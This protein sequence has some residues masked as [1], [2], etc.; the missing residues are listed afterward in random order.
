MTALILTTILIVTVLCLRHRQ[1]KSTHRA[2]SVD[3]ESTISLPRASTPRQ[4]QLTTMGSM[5]LPPHTN[6][7]AQRDH[8]LTLPYH[9]IQ[10]QHIIP[11]TGCV[12]YSK[13]DYAKVDSPCHFRPV[14]LSHQSDHIHSSSPSTV[15][16][17]VP[18]MSDNE[19][20][21]IRECLGDTKNNNMVPNSTSTPAPAV[22]PPAL[23]VGQIPPH[24]QSESA[25]SP[26]P[27]YHQIQHRSQPGQPT[28]ASLPHPH[29][30]L[31]TRTLWT[32]DGRPYEAVTCP[33]GV[34]HVY[35]PLEHIYEE[36][37]MW[38]RTLQHPNAV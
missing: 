21:T 20:H 30:H 34:E 3:S 14:I 1:R 9:R 29:Q 12:E 27:N 7:T 19:F 33:H 5:R 23:P 25:V 38:T 15:Q 31:R 11:G 6:N 28:V 32:P 22:S 8:V 35:Q 4:S 24:S 17:D 10:C 18:S 26:P 13:A 2:E 37:R 36:P 16:S